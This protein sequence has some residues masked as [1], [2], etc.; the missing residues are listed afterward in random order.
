MKTSPKMMK[1]KQSKDMKSE[2]E[3]G[4]SE[5]EKKNF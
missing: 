1:L 4:E 2:N 5:G 3:K